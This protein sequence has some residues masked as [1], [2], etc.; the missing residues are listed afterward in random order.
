M[1]FALVGLDLGVLACYEDDK[2]LPLVR[3]EGGL[4]RVARRTGERGVVLDSVVDVE[5]G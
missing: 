3:R 5:V 4:E 1:W 2:E